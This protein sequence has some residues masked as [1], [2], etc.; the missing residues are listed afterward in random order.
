MSVHRISAIAA[1]Q[2]VRLYAPPLIK[3]TPQLNIHFSPPA[4][5]CSWRPR[6]MQAT[7]RLGNSAGSLFENYISAVVLCKATDEATEKEENFKRTYLVNYGK[8]IDVLTRELPLYMEKGIVTVSIYD[9]NIVYQEP[10]YHR[11]AIKGLFA[12]KCVSNLTCFL[13]NCCYYDLK[14]VVL[15]VDDTV[16][17]EARVRW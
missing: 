8:A 6:P 10:H 5:A 4:K 17:R 2:R 14:L 15:G 11:F 7:S 3:C 1:Q 12:Y 16:D 13:F 9:Q